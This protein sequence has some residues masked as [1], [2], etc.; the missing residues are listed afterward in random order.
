[1]LRNAKVFGHLNGVF[2]ALKINNSL[3][4]KD[5]YFVPINL[6]I[7]Y[8]HSDSFKYGHYFYQYF[9]SKYPALK[10]LCCGC[11]MSCCTLEGL[12]K[13]ILIRIKLC[14]LSNSKVPF[15]YLTC[16]LSMITNL[17]FVFCLITP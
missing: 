4:G 11:Y 8:Y 7:K 17:L 6:T 12:E 3:K 9:F 1:M 14:M 10:E 13:K 16:S 15:L 5:Q 2:G